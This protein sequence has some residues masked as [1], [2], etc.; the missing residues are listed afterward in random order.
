M[1]PILDPRLVADL[2]ASN[3]LDNVDELIAPLAES[4]INR[5]QTESVSLTSNARRKSKAAEMVFGLMYRD[6][7]ALRRVANL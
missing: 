3:Y 5:G 1:G 2:S 6:G 7:A 4:I